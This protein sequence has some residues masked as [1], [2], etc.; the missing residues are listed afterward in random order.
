MTAVRIRPEQVHVVGMHPDGG[1]AMGGRIMESFPWDRLGGCY[2]YSA[3]LQSLEALLIDAA[4][5]GWQILSGSHSDRRG[6]R[7]FTVGLGAWGWRG[8]VE[9][10]PLE[11][12]AV[13]PDAADAPDSSAWLSVAQDRLRA[14]CLRLNGSEHPFA[15]SALRWLAGLYRKLGVPLEPEEYRQA[16]PVDVAAMCR[17]AH[18]GGPIVH[19][20]SSCAPFVTL[21]RERAY[22]QAMRMDV[23][24]GQPAEVPLSGSGLDRWRDRDLMRALGVAEATVRVEPGP[25]IPLLP[26]QRPSSRFDRARTLYPTG[27]FR[28]T[29]C[30]PE[31][32]DLE[33]RGRGKVTALH[34]VVTFDG[35]PVLRPVIDLLRALEADLPCK[36]KRLEHMLY[37]RWALA[38]GVTRFGSIAGKRRG[39]ARDILEDRTMRRVEGGVKTRRRGLGGRNPPGHALWEVVA[40]LSPSVEWGAVDR[41]DRAAIVPARN[42]IAMNAVLDTLDGALGPSRSGAYVGRIYVDGMDIEALPHQLPSIH[43]VV[44]RRHG[45]RMQIHRAGAVVVEIGS[46][47]P[48]VEA[49]SLAPVDATEEDLRRILRVTADPGGGP[50]AEGRVWP[51]PSEEGVDPRD[52]P[53]LQSVPL[54]LAPGFDRL[55]MADDQD[56]QRPVSASS[57]AAASSRSEGNSDSM[58]PIQA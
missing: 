29:W 53:D 47:H 1:W 8:R 57:T 19:A 35:I 48:I 31:L 2:C 52:L 28:G 42:R 9:C 5:R 32:A 12:W 18:V 22:G 40:R 16:L 23:P 43:G 24:S 44:V 4:T 46:G 58:A 37:G 38:L 51:E 21:D 20:R 36:M 45:S 14:I 56:D 7:G 3:T 27:E 33:R 26:L 15:A 50:F 25:L 17:R 11:A 13:E 55:W 30:L 41:P 34:R 54:H 49:G 6:L 39:L 10:R